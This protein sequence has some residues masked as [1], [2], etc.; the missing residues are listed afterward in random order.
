MNKNTIINVTNANEKGE[1]KMNTI[2]NHKEM[3]VQGEKALVLYNRVSKEDI[4]WGQRVKTGDHETMELLSKELVTQVNLLDFEPVFQ[5]NKK[6]WSIKQAGMQDFLLPVLSPEELEEILPFALGNIDK[7]SSY[8]KTLLSQG[9]RVFDGRT[10][11]KAELSG[12]SN[13]VVYA[14]YKDLLLNDT[15]EAEKL[16][17]MKPGFISVSSNRA[18]SAG[19]INPTTTYRS[20]VQRRGIKTES[21]IM[22]GKFD[23]KKAATR[24]ELSNSAG[25]QTDLFAGYTFFSKSIKDFDYFGEAVF[26][27]VVCLKHA[28][29]EDIIIA[30]LPEDFTV[31]TEETVLMMKQDKRG[32]HFE[33]LASQFD[34]PASDGTLLA[35]PR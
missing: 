4:R 18:G 25:T 3:E 32:S 12:N 28:T 24:V 17:A 10:G 1:Y 6:I 14:T 30:F 15:V 11:V 20:D 13:E 22:N 26:A 2:I 21:F 16:I 31:R 29:K 5:L 9:V 23:A 19:V 33:L 27:E 8:V 35:D 7:E 34:K